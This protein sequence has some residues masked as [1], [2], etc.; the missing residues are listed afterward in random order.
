[1]DESG[2]SVTTALRACL[3]IAVV[4]IGSPGIAQ[5]PFRVTYTVKS[6]A[7]PA[8]VLDGRVVNDSGREVVDV[9][10]TAEALSA[11][12]K[13]LA[14]GIAFVR[15]VIAKGDTAAFLAKVPFVEGAE[16]FRIAV[17]SYRLGSDFQSP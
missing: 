1:V 11:S 10:V 5:G 9:W 2:W 13:V 16:N 14:T 15:S 7:A 12:G 8:F 4:L 3:V 17:T 6:R